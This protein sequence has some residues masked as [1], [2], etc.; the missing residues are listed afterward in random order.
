MPAGPPGVGARKRAAL[1]PGEILPLFN[2]TFVRSCELLE[3]YVVRL[4]AAVFR[5]TGLE[6]ACGGAVTV[7]EAIAGS[8]LAPGIARVPVA[9]LLA[10]LAARGWVSRI[11]CPGDAARYQALQSAPV[12]EAEIVLSEQ[13]ELDASCLPSYRI[14]ALAAERYPAVLRGEITGEQALFDPE[15]IGAWLK[16]FS[17]AN[18]LYAVTNAIGSIAA[19]R[20]L[21]R[22]GGEVLELGGGFGSGAEALLARLEATG[23]RAE[24]SSYRLTEL[25]AMFLRRADK[26]L[27]AR[28]ARWPLAFGALDIN[29]PFAEGGVAPGS[30]ALVYGVNVVHVA[31]DLAATLSEIR[32]ALGENGALV[33]AECVRPFPGR[34]IYVEFAFNLLG[35]FRDAVLVPDWRPNGGFL[36]PEQW[37]AA[38]EANGFTDV[39]VFPDIAAIRQD[40][41]Q[42]VVAAISARRA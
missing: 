36:T 35:T 7:D 6:R 15:G 3:E 16:Y 28:F 18:P 34:P 33:L 39:R 22:G 9:W 38:L 25:V 17:N 5:S 24:V 30:A 21:P 40:I 1:I 42:F 2:D 19:E 26:A 23:R 27:R 32:A 12:L 10:M 29:R 8:G 13:T 4:A 37:T 14:A 11:D 20:A 31:R 41:P